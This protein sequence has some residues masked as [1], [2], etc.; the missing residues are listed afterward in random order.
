[1]TGREFS[2]AVFAELFLIAALI[3]NVTQFS[4][5]TY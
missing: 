1:M 2:D 3:R 5:F 4:D